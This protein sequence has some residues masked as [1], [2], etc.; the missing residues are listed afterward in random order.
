MKF[1]H[2]IETESQNGGKETSGQTFVKDVIII[3]RGGRSDIRFEGSLMSLE[4]ARLYESGK[5]LIV[6]DLNSLTGILVNGSVV[7][8]A[9]L[10]P[11]DKLRVG[12]AAFSITKEGDVWGVKERREQKAKLD[13]AERVKEVAKRLDVNRALPPFG[14]VALILSIVFGIIYGV[15]PLLGVNRYSWTDGQLTASHKMIDKQCNSCHGSPFTAVKDEK[16]ISCHK[17][18]EH[19]VLY[20]KTIEESPSKGIRCA[21]CH[22]EHKGHPALKPGESKLCTECHA[23][24]KNFSPE[25]K[26]GDVTSFDA[27]PQFK[28]T[29]L[30]PDKQTDPPTYYRVGL[31]DSERLHDG[32]RLKLNHKIHLQEGLRGSNGPTTLTC[33]DC[34]KLS[35]DYR[36]MI[37]ITFEASCRSCH[38]LGFDERLE[39]NQTPHGNADQVFNYMY[40]EYAKLFLATQAEQ[41]AQEE[42]FVRFRPGQEAASAPAARTEYVRKYVE[43]ESRVAEQLI[44]TRTGCKTC[45]EIGPKS[46]TEAEDGSDSTGLLSKFH[47]VKPSL[48]KRWMTESTFSHGAHSEIKCE[49]CH[50]GARDS[51]KT[52]DVLLPKIESCRGCHN[53]SGKSGSAPA[54]CI[55]CHSFHDSID[56][57]YEKKRSAEDILDSLKKKG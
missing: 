22:M 27:H 39:G 38:P 41:T 48:P 51:E 45:H 15:F 29:L 19:A 18:S 16:C 28:V 47:I 42:G 37:P 6:E 52:S 50:A 14:L 55:E 1:V 53:E 54:N 56:F 49:S 34:H 26:A 17:I 11:G 23:N 44:F 8:R 2:V 24:L 12:D 30:D 43:A 13:S 20:T 10:K 40:A 21:T 25:A 33:A 57:P 7:G 36:T 9:E 31:D 4:H 3:G 5:A 32:T 46:E 35:S